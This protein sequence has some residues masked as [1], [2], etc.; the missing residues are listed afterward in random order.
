MGFEDGTSD[1][2]ADWMFA[3]DE[4]A[5]LPSWVHVGPVS[6]SRYIAQLH[7]ALEAA[8]VPRLVPPTRPPDL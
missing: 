4:I 1:Y 3:L 7:E 5:H 6:V 2:H 8:G